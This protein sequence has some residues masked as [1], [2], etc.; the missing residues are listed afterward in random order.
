[1]GHSQDFRFDVGYLVPH[2]VD[3]RAEERTMS[4]QTK[5]GSNRETVTE[6]IQIMWNQHNL[7]LA[8]NF[9]T[10]AMAKETI[11][12][13]REIFDAFSDLTVD[14]LEPGLIAEDDHVVMRLRVSGVHDS[15]PFAGQPPSGKRVTWESIRIMRLENGLI[16][17]TW[18]MQ[19]R[20][21]LMEQL[22]AIESRAGEVH[23]AAG[24]DSPS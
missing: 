2:I 1:M 12:H 5:A 10:S 8:L 20:L 23:W 7:D 16:A 13:V 24:G 19:D 11:P 21:G 4:D 6:Y 22:G 14:V 15:A 3:R 9:S 18:A 17:E